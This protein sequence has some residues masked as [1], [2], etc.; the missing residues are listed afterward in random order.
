[1]WNDAGALVTGAIL[2][3]GLVAFKT[4]NKSMSQHMMRA[5]VLAQGA[6]VALMLGTSGMVVVVGRYL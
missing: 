1:V 5:R 6:T 2:G 4:G 3:A